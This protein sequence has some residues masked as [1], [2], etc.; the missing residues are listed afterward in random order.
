[1]PRPSGTPTRRLACCMRPRFDLRRLNKNIGHPWPRSA[2]LDRTRWHRL[3]RAWRWAVGPDGVEMLGPEIVEAL[4]KIKM[5]FDPEQRLNRNIVEA[6]SAL[7]P[8]RIDGRHQPLTEPEVST[9]WHWPEGLATATG[10]C[11]GNGL[12]R[13]ETG[14]AMCPSCQQL[15]KNDMPPGP[16]QRF[17]K[18][19][20]PSEPNFSDPDLL[21]P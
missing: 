12:C 10:S 1:M 4:C 16:R 3:G 15:G 13:K 5:L 11:N 6:T 21:R 20:A 8:L 18:V 14:G 2:N 9:F 17:G 7:V 19:V